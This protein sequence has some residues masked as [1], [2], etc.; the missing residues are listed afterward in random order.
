MPGILADAADIKW[1]VQQL[2]P[3]HDVTVH[4]SRTDADLAALDCAGEDKNP[5]R[6]IAGH[7]KVGVSEQVSCD[8]NDLFNRK[9]APF[10]AFD[11]PAPGHPRITFDREKAGHEPCFA[12]HSRL[13]PGKGQPAGGGNFRLEPGERQP[14]TVD[15]LLDQLDLVPFVT[16]I[17]A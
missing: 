16:F 3:D 13:C 11:L 6:R 2:P 1:V 9:L 10:Q 4:I 15:D 17:A 14:F 7:R 8:Q 5:R 12:G